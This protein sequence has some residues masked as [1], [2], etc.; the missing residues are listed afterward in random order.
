[1]EL[2]YMVL[3]RIN[4]WTVL[5]D[6]IEKHDE[7]YKKLIKKVQPYSQGKQLTF[8]RIRIDGLRVKRGYITQGFEDF[9]D[10]E[11]HIHSYDEDEDMRH[12]FREWFSCIDQSSFQVAF[13][14]E[15]PV[16]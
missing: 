12:L 14:E 6:K 3:W 1:M 10:W 5:Q 13:W 11:T 2:K 16:D 4:Q 15:I 7:V 8:F 9:A